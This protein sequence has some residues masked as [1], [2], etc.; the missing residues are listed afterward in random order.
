MLGKLRFSPDGTKLFHSTQNEVRVWGIREHAMLCQCPGLL[1]GISR[2]SQTFLTQSGQ[3]GFQAWSSST[4]TQLNLA[5]INPNSYEQY[6]RSVLLP[7]NKTLILEI[8][9]ILNE[10]A[11]I[12]L[13]INEIKGHTLLEIFENWAMA[14]DGEN[15]AVT[16][17]GSEAGHDWTTGLC[18]G[19]DGKKR[20]GFGVN[21]FTGTP[22]LY[23]AEYHPLLAVETHHS[24][25]EI[26]HLKTH[27]PIHRVSYQY[28]RESAFIRI[29]PQSDLLT[30]AIPDTASSFRVLPHLVGEGIISEPEPIIDVMFHPDGKQIASLLK[31]KKIRI[32]NLE[33]LKLE[34]A[35]E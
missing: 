33:T 19:L 5:G 30:I 34:N 32:Y 10:P 21:R 2:D 31:N 29:G 17:Y 22:L 14:P 6:Q 7:D 18:L 16:L 12:R 1:V 9:D 4:G 13:N 24:L 15:I 35:F 23:F 25:I 26:F 27:K 11:S 28:N 8:R 3:N 20:F